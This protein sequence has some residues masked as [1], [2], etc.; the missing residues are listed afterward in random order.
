[1][2]SAVTTSARQGK[3]VAI[4]QSNYIPWKGYFDMIAAVDEFILL[5]DVQ[6]TKRDWRNRNLIKTAQG[7]QWLTIPVA[8]KGRQTQ[9]IDETEI[10]EPWAEQHWG[11]IRHSYG[12]APYFRAYE[13]PL[14]GLYEAAAGLT[15]LSDINRVL[16]EGLCKLL[17]I[18]TPLARSRDYASTG[19]KTEK[20]LTLCQSA[21][22][23]SYLSGPSAR[24]YLNEAAFADAGIA[25]SWMEYG[26][27]PVY[28]Q[29]YGEFD[30]YVSVIDLLFNTGPEARRHMKF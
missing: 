10:S 3:R 11:R 1:M 16:L 7:A 21:A 12:K 25:V 14:A 23:V 15:R 19:S 27:Y 5:D 20:L 22:A 26:G 17:N 29:L 30:H 28:P 13:A 8:N 2:S 9:L 4:V 24:N 6:Y 18:G